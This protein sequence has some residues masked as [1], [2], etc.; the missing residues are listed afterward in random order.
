MAAGSSRLDSK[1]GAADDTAFRQ[2]S[3]GFV[4]QACFSRQVHLCHSLTGSHDL[5]IHNKTS[6]ARALFILAQHSCKHLVMKEQ[7]QIG[8]IVASSVFRPTRRLPP[9]RCAASAQVNVT[10]AIANWEGVGRKASARDNRKGL[11]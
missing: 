11:K 2:G 1:S 8:K 3:F 6:D 4:V 10:V 7:S 9:R 5:G